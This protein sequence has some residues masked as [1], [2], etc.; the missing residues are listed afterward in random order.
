LPAPH[1]G[2][3]AKYKFVKADT[4]AADIIADLSKMVETKVR[5]I[6]ID[7]NAHKESMRNQIV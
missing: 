5:R 3:I 1:T 7:F 2:N 4:T 6:R